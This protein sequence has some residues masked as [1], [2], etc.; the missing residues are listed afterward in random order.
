MPV[1][2]SFLKCVYIYAFDYYYYTY[3]NVLLH[4]FYLIQT[5][6]VECLDVVCSD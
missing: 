4:Y 5:L 3:F 6:K 2:N 1:Q